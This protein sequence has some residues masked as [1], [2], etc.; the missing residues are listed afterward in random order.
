M[1]LIDTLAAFATDTGLHLVGGDATG[2][3]GRHLLAGHRLGSVAAGP[4]GTLWLLA[5]RRH[6]HRLVLGGADDAG[7]EPELVASLPEGSAGVCV[8][9]HRG[10]V[11]VGGDRAGLW[12]LDDD[13]LVPVTTFA[14]AP[15]HDVWYT[16]WG[17]PP[18]VF[19]LASAGDSLYVSVHVGGILRTDDDGITWRSTLDLHDDV[20]Q[21]A[22]GPDGRLW[23]ATGERGLAAS[24]DGGATWHHH[25]DGLEGNNY[26]LALAPTTDG[27]I[28][29]AARS[30]ASREGGL[31]RFDG[32]RFHHLGPAEGLPQ[33]LGGVVGPRQLAA[34][35]D[36]VVVA[37]PSGRVMRSADGGRSWA[38]LPLPP[39]SVAEVALA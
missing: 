28:V 34:S 18:A 2:S 9:L 19:S 13:R 25:H 35:G 8:G 10:Q 11:W 29:A 39:V 36:V 6:L 31:Y 14:T 27:V 4:D 24:A 38:A 33:P 16:P 22:V 20:H 23:A 26:A 3:P 30:H 32:T 1:N 5:D 12:R 37:L 15:T 21:V 17:G 7:H